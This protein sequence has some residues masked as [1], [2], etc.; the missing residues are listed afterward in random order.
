[1]CALAAQRGDELATNSAHAVQLS[2]RVFAH[3]ALIRC[4]PP[5]AC[6]CL[7]GAHPL[8]PSARVCLPTQ[9]PFTCHSLHESSPTRRSSPRTHIQPNPTD[10]GPTQR[11]RVVVVCVSQHPSPHNQ[12]QRQGGR[13]RASGAVSLPPTLTPTPY[14]ES[15]SCRNTMFTTSPIPAHGVLTNVREP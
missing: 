12:A 8:S 4:R 13:D 14:C 7:R 2:A 9:R 1:V 5:H 6:V 11:V 10:N 3:A 15:D